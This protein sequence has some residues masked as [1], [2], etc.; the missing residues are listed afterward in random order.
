VI[1]EKRRFKL[2]LSPWFK[3][4]VAYFFIHAIM[5]I[6]L[7][8]VTA[9]APDENNYL[10]IFKSV[11]RG[12]STLDGFAGWPIQNEL[13][14]E[15]I[16]FPATVLVMFGFTE[17]QSIRILSS[18][19]SYLSLFVLYSLAG[20]NRVMGMRQKNW[21]TFGFFFPSIILWSTLG[22]RESFIFLWLS[23]I[24]YFLKKFLDSSRAVHAIA[25][26]SSSA[27]LVLTKNYLYAIFAIA[28]ILSTFIIVV[29]RRTFVFSY[30]VILSMVLAPVV[31]SPEIRISLLTGAKFVVG[32]KIVQQTPISPSQTVTEPNIDPNSD[33]N[34]KVDRGETLQSVLDQAEN[35]PIFSIIVKESGIDEQ[36]NFQSD[37]TSS[38]S[39]SNQSEDVKPTEPSTAKPAQSG[40]TFDS[41]PSA[42]DPSKDVVVEE[43]PQTSAQEVKGV[44]ESREKLMITPASL[45]DPVSLFLGVVGFVVKPFPFFDN[46]SFFINVLSYESFFW[47]PI[48]G[49]LATIIYR[50]VRG[51]NE[52]DLSSTTAILFIIGFLIQSA[53]LEI[54]V[55]T[56]YRHRSILLIGILA[57]CAIFYDQ[58]DSAQKGKVSV[59]G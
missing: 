19:V 9:F 31:L 44:I 35:N 54:N 11:V 24:F 6:I 21:I 27:A 26:L 28:C 42:K 12:D 55:G 17:L 49:L 20:D 14:L 37:S 29:A 45:R 30:L 50:M 56:A 15:L 40:P 39:P 33:S 53:L 59:V 48:Y 47:Y 22:L 34:S 5:I 2:L 46:G 38:T 3:I 51:K 23:C 8:E 18:L 4:S 57:L 41:D 43:T 16:Y 58:R 32:Q 1:S 10:G 7:D 52:W 13:F 25:L 36:L